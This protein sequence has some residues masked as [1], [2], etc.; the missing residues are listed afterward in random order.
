M[1][2]KVGFLLVFLSAL[3]VYLDNKEWIDFFPSN[4]A[5]LAAFVGFLIAAFSFYKSNHSYDRKLL[6]VN[7]CYA[8]STLFLFGQYYYL[9]GGGGGELA[10]FVLAGSSLLF[11]P[12]S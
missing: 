9:E 11:V 12:P 8:I 4:V 7:S 2:N 1:M 5:V 10:V 3:S 6:F